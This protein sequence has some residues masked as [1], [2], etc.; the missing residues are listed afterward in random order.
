M[1]DSLDKAYILEAK[2]IL[3][4]GEVLEAVRSHIKNLEKYFEETNKLTKIDSCSFY[5]SNQLAEKL[6][7]KMVSIID[8]FKAKGVP[9]NYY[10]GYEV[11]FRTVVEDE[12]WTLDIN[13][14]TGNARKMSDLCMQIIEDA[15]KQGVTKI[16]NAGYSVE[17]SKQAI[18][19]AEKYD[20][21]YGTVRYIS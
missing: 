15:Y 4:N 21:V 5:I 2:R 18:E 13:I 17:S 20:F 1:K 16:V 6:Y 9:P 14:P 12:V 19:L 8:N 10:H 11:T 3:N 7:E